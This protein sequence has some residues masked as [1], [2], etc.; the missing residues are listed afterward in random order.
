MQDLKDKKAIMADAYSDKRV[1]ELTKA[2]KT[3][4]QMEM[5]AKAKKPAGKMIKV[6]KTVKKAGDTKETLLKAKYSM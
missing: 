6:M 4:Y 3:P 1:N 2:T 5:A